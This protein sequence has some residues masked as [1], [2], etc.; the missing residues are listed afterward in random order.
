MAQTSREIVRK[1]LTFDHPERIARHSWILPWARDHFAD[2]IDRLG[3]EFPDDIVN[4]PGVYSASPLVNGDPYEVGTYIDEWGCEFENIHKGIIGEVK[5]PAVE[6]PSDLSDLHIPYEIL[7]KDKDAAARIVN[8]FCAGSDKF[9]LGGCCPRPW[10][11]MQFLRGTV[12]AMM[13]LMSPG[14]GAKELIARIHSFYMAELE[15]WTS[16][17]VDGVMFMDDWGSQ[18]SLL[19]PPSLWEEIF[20]PLYKQYC[21][22]AHKNGKFIFMHSDGYITAIYPHLVEIGV[23]AINSQLFCMDMRE[24]AQIA[25]GKITFWGEIDRQHVMPSDDTQDAIDAV[26]KVA[27]MLYDPAGGVIA[28]FEIGPGTNIDNAFAVYRQWGAIGD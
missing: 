28:Q 3:R 19:I 15:F 16:T 27:S 26:N 18:N 13:D 12:N 22:I 4:A 9:V 24:L 1:T 23:D 2:E 8:E 20:K 7:P 21:D 17:D 5:K 6:D 25:K 10:E 14:S 11:R